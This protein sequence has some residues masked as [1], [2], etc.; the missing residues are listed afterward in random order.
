MPS[1]Y[2]RYRYYQFVAVNDPKAQAQAPSVSSQ[3]VEDP[4][5]PNLSQ[6]LV[7]LV[8]VS[9]SKTYTM[10]SKPNLNFF[11]FFLLLIKNCFVIKRSGS[12]AKWIAVSIR[13]L[14]IFV[15]MVGSVYYVIK[16]RKGT[17]RYLFN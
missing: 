7:L 8:W 17:S 14:E 15:V 5:K 10:N 11:P 3:S 16:R 6:G 2:I 12:K 4:M 9:F 1:Y 13:L